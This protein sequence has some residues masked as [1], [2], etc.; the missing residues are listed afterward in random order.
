M[1]LLTAKDC[2]R[3]N[4]SAKIVRS[5]ESEAMVTN[6]G[7]SLLI[8][9]VQIAGV[10]AGKPVGISRQHEERRIRRMR[11]IAAV[12]LAVAVALGTAVMAQELMKVTGL[13]MKIDA[14][15]LSVTILPQVGDAVTV[16]MNDPESLSKVKLGDIAEARYRVMDGKNVGRWLRNMSE[17]C[18]S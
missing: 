4:G 2:L 7:T 8:S 6:K 5:S 11:K 1:P 16:I 17:G 18:S 13:V 9:C 3:S 14:A 15:A 10:F 12:V